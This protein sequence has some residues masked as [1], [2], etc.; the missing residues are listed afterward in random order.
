MPKQP[1]DRFHQDAERPWHHHGSTGR[2]PTQARYRDRRSRPG[3]LSWREL[4]SLPAG[5][6]R[7][8]LNP[9]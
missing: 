7:H 5:A 3:R 8:H 2:F 6:A 4:N 1:Q 9:H